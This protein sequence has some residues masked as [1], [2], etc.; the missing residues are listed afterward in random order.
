VQ[1]PACQDG[2]DVI[3]FVL[4]SQ[5]PLWLPFGDQAFREEHG[6]GLPSPDLGYCTSEIVVPVFV[7]DQ[8]WGAM[9]AASYE[10]DVRYT[11]VHQETLQILAN[12]TAVTLCNVRQLQAAQQLEAA[13]AVLAGQRGRK[14][15]LRAIV[16]E[17]HNLIGHEYTS[18]VLQNEDGALQKAYPVM[19]EGYADP[20]EEPRQQDGITRQVIESGKPLVV[21][22]AQRDPRVKQSMRQA[23]VRSIMATPMIHGHQVL[24]VLFTHTYEPWHF[25]LH[26]QNLW[27]TFASYAA[28]ILHRAQQEERSE[29]WKTLDDQIAACNDRFTL[30]RLFAQH[31]MAALHADF[32]VYYPYDPT[33]TT[34]LPRL[35]LEECVY[36]GQLRTPWQVPQGGGHGGVYE[37]INQAP[38]GLLIVNHLDELEGALQSA[39]SRREGLKAFVGLR[40]EATSHDW[41]RPRAVGMLFLNYRRP[42]RFQRADL[43]G[44]R[45]AGNRVAAAVQKLYLLEV[46]QRQ[47]RQLN[48]RLRVIV[49][50]FRAYQ[51]GRDTRAILD[52][53]AVAAQAAL[54]LDLCLLIEYDADRGQFLDRPPDVGCS[55]G[56]IPAVQAER[57]AALLTER[58]G[59]GDVPCAIV[60]TSQD[61]WL[62]EL[63]QVREREISTLAICPI[64]IEGQFL[65]LLLAGFSRAKRIAADD[66]ET[67]AL[68]ATLAGLIVGEAHLQQS[69]DQTRRR[70]RSREFLQWVSMVD[71]SW[72]H[73]VGSKASTIRNCVG[74]LRRQLSRA[75]APSEDDAVLGTI[76]QIDR[77]AHDIA[78]AHPKVP[79]SW[80][81]ESEIL[82]LAPL[83]EEVVQRMQEPFGPQVAHSIDIQAHVEELSGVRVR[84]YRRWLIYAVEAL[85]QNA[86]QAMPDGGTVT[87]SGQC[88]NGWAE[89]RVQDTGIGVPESVRSKLFREL[90]PKR[91]D[92][93]GMGIGCL[94]TA[95][96]VEDHEG[97]IELER[98]GPGNTTVLVR[99]PTAGEPV[100]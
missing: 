38:D 74:I 7:K 69:L 87:V 72:R 15:V 44:L 100:S 93:E 45:L 53:I 58:G 75:A 28:T 11:R 35:V 9:Q 6:L 96:I 92:E 48:E 22:D 95:N 23:G 12:Q 64:G 31:A 37:A 42:T 84:G 2:N 27:G 55:P 29:I 63:D 1:I 14:A 94:L 86:C 49:E 5:K 98:P 26:E 52:R 71:N 99:L 78:A 54:R 50:V 32:A 33:G 79:Q 10:P 61:E 60:E 8:I 46:L 76:D 59:A 82:P 68:F 4:T 89:I 90:I 65:G 85:L 34:P 13:V 66:K 39:L 16:I 21:P 3:E 80:E 17:A 56:G 51:K 18:L 97:S 19:P 25:D 62:R 81:L 73:S 88:A 36:V 77:L 57:L 41:S 43:L 30:Y 47:H 67:L 83:L 24:G 91:H 40:L 70:L 20:F